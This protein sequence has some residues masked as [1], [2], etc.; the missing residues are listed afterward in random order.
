MTAQKAALEDHR[1][2]VAAVE[3][4]QAGQKSEIDALVHTHDGLAKL[5]A[6]EGQA[7]RAGQG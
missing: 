5:D 6:T 4:R 2:A 1:V 7:D 3:K